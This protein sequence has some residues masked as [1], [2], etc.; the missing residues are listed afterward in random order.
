MLELRI[1]YFELGIGRNQWVFDTLCRGKPGLQGEEIMIDTFS[2]S[3][4]IEVLL[5]LQQ[6]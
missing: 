4:Q 3:W 5:Q 2:L 6:C 1:R